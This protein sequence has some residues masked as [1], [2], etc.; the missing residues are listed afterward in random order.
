[1]TE[2]FLHYLWQNKLFAD[3]LT[4]TLGE[5]IE[6]IHTGYHN[7]NAGPD[8]SDARLV[9]SNTKWAG[10]IEIHLN[11]SDWFK[12]GH[13][14]DEA[15]N[16]VVL[17]VV[18]NNDI[19]Q[20]MSGMPVCELKGKVNL[21]LYEAYESFLSKKEFVPCFNDLTTISEIDLTLWLERMLIEKLQSKSDF[22][23]D[24]LKRSQNDWGEAF[25]QV[26]ARSFG[27]KVNSLPFEML[28]RNLPLRI[29]A[30]HSDSLFQTEALL[31]GQAGLLSQELLDP[32]SQS[33]FNEYIFLRKKYQ[34]AP[35]SKSLWKFLRMRPVN[36]PTIRLAQLAA[37]IQST[38]GNLF[39]I[40]SLPSVDKMLEL[41]DVSASDYWHTHYVFDVESP[42]KSGH[43]GLKASYLLI[44]NAVLPFM[45]VYG[46][47]C[48]N[49]DLC[50]KALSFLD[51]IPG[52]EN[53]VISKWEQAGIHAPTAS[54][55]Q[56]LMELKSSYCDNKKCLHCRIGNLIIRK[57]EFLNP[58]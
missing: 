50:H 42:S 24:A 26:L 19:E 12:H 55:S 51:Q 13:H 31:F 48:G 53:S 34:L 3:T 20:H 17:H 1:M 52:E 16:N 8:F 36:F 57:P 45:F 44:V 54:K 46:S 49:D 22:I 39:K 38:S 58:M 14:H 41:F 6:I 9:I 11:A 7:F 2:D 32:Y 25:Y 21:K 37:V 43:L 27:F 40:L 29:L 33:L 47:S 28:S 10:N 15:Y 30:K 35:I 23:N 56:A 4:T 18:Y 5:Q